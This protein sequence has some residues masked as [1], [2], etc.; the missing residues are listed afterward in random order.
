MRV[1]SF[2]VGIKNLAACII[3]WSDGTNIK[4]NLNIHYWDIINLVQSQ[5]DFDEIS[6]SCFNQGCKTKPKSFIEFNSVKYCF[7]TKH[8]AK[9]DE[10]LSDIVKLCPL[11]SLEKIRNKRA[12]EWIHN[13]SSILII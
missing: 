9:K 4:S 1:L 13:K 5:Q 3:D 8:L 6:Y 11:K 2:D 12:K 10:L 7:C